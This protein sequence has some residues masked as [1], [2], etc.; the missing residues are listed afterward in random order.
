M[1]YLVESRIEDFEN[2][3]EIWDPESIKQVSK[4]IVDLIRKIS[5]KEVKIQPSLKSM[6]SLDL[7]TVDATNTDKPLIVIS[8]HPEQS[9][10]LN[11][12]RKILTPEYQV[13]CSI[14]IETEITASNTNANAR[15]ITDNPNLTP[16]IEENST[17]TH[18]TQDY[19]RK[20]AENSKQRPKSVPNNESLVD[21]ELKLNLK[22]KDLVRVMSLN[23]ES[24]YLSSITPERMERLKVFQEKVLL[25]SLVIILASEKFYKSRT[26]EQHVFYC[27]LRKKTIR[28]QCD[29]SQEP[30]WFYNLMSNDYSLVY[31]EKSSFFEAKLKHK[32]HEILDPKV[33]CVNDQESKIKY[34]ADC[35]KRNVPN[36]ATCVYVFGTDDLNNPRTVEICQEIGRQL[37]A[38]QNINIVT[39]GFFGSGD[40]VAHTFVQ[41]RR[42]SK[43][44]DDCVIH[45][46]PVKDSKNYRSKCRQNSDNTFEKVT[47]G[48][49]LFLGES[50]EERDSVL[51]QLLDTCILIG[52]DESKFPFCDKIC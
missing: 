25:S 21:S 13:W 9:H 8:A 7:P 12:I 3:D 23:G 35:M 43:N 36:L 38:V 4:Q 10:V 6:P 50:V 1:I 28:I 20:I 5:K 46:V 40:L 14:D 52:G 51:A 37:A 27:G 2:K 17:L 11:E 22:K 33:K 41:E 29:K 45:I 26:S 31:D 42:I 19:A 32:V 39:N 48:Q 34:L 44:E 30:V 24:S 16:I 18:P 15:Q 47:Y 49:T